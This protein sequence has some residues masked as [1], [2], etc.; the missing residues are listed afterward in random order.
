MLPL[1][2][3]NQP[4]R[5]GQPTH[6]NHRRP[7]SIILSPETKPVDKP[8][9]CLRV[10]RIR[11]RFDQHFRSIPFDQFGDLV[12]ALVQ[13]FAIVAFRSE[14]YGISVAGLFRSGRRG[15][16]FNSCHSD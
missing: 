11:Q 13:A 12:Q 8:L 16:M 15:R 1:E 3:R 9:Q 14:F 5:S 2:S 10:E 4:N 6:Q 7:Q